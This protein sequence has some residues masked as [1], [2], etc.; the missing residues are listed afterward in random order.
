MTN[1][2]VHKTMPGV[3]GIHL[4]VSACVI[5]V[6]NAVS[7]YP[8]IFFGLCILVISLRAKFCRVIIKSCKRHRCN[9]AC[10]IYLANHD[11]H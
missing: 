5:S 8:R 6:C 2:R 10:R 9:R 1:K 11:K 4:V 3:G 7:G